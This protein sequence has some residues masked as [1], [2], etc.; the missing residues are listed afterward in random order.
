MGMTPAS[1]AA[2]NNFRLDINLLR[3]IAVAGVVLYHFR[4]GVF[5]GGFAGVDL[6]FVVSGY[7]MTRIIVD[8]LDRGNFSLG[9]FYAARARRIVPALGALCVVLLAISQLWIDPLTRREIAAGIVSSMLFLSNFAFWREAGYF[10]VAAQSKWLLHTWS[11]SVEWQFYLVLPLVLIALR[12][13][14]PG[15]R[16][17]LAAFWAGTILS[18][19]LATML[20]GTRPSFTFY[21]L[22]TRAWEMLAG[23]LVYLHC[24]GWRPRAWLSNLLALVGLALIAIAFVGLDVLVAW[25]SWSTLLPVLGA[26]LVLVARPE[27]AP[28]LGSRPVL[29]IGLWSYSI[30]IWHWPIVVGLAYAGFDG[31]GAALAGMAATIA[32]AGLSYRFIETPFRQKPLP[33]RRIAPR[34]AMLAGLAVL[35]GTTAGSFVATGS[36]G[37][38]GHALTAR[39]LAAEQAMADGA[40]PPECGGLTHRDALRPC[41]IGGPAKRN[42]LFIGDSHAELFFTHFEDGRP[43]HAFTF[44]TYG[45]CAPLPGTDQIMPGARC[46]T[47]V[48][49]ALEQAA[50]GDYQEVVVSAYW[51]IYLRPFRTHGAN[52]HLLCFEPAQG[53]RLERDPERYRAGISAAF[54]RLAAEIR[55]LRDKGIAV[56]L[57]MPLPDAAIDIPRESVKRAYLG[58]EPGGLQPIDRAAAQE[59]AAEARALLAELAQ[60]TGARLLDPLPSMCE[61][62][63]CVASRDDLMPD[64]RDTNHLT[65]R[66]IRDGRLEFI[67]AAVLQREEADRETSG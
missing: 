1:P 49:K 6:F 28:G 45:G 48:D 10:D 7:L 32:V 66:A 22:P 55:T 11:L 67:D 43:G 47:F 29:A 36:A 50:S 65:A 33:G 19:A 8:G 64:Y 20:A 18:F 38:P 5:T 15:R 3:A 30:Y 13:R 24:G 14:L 23:G 41:V 17:L 27:K 56:T 60:E 46:R 31:T 40:Y 9:G 51:P 26:V 58:V 57:V 21:L 44:L 4:I 53:C 35:A 34:L 59:R 63:H 52:N 54:E 25:P 39:T 42:V 61:A 16:F 62:T 37:A 12:R 2:G